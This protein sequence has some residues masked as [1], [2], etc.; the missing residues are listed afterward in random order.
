MTFEYKA[1]FH[2]HSKYSDGSFQVE[3]LVDRVAS[4]NKSLTVEKNISIKGLA[5]V[6]HDFYPDESTEAAAKAYA[7]KYGIELLFGSEISADNDKVHIVGYGIDASNFSFQRHVVKEQ[8]KRLEAFEATCRLLNNFFRREG[9]NIDLDRDVGPK[10]LKRDAQGRIEPNGPL[11]WHYLRQAMVERGMAT[12][13]KEAN[14]LIGPVGPCYHQRETI[15][16]V[17][18]VERVLKWGGK[19][20]LAHP[21]KIPE[22]YR[23][24][25][26][27]S[28]CKAGLLGIEAYTG[29][30]H[31]PEAKNSYVQI[32]KDHNLMVLSGTDLHADIND[33]GKFLLPYEVLRDFE[34]FQSKFHCH[35]G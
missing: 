7:S 26:V 16:S 9:K 27:K 31:E 8:Y 32:A 3:A 15:D 2:N 12:T 24:L 21:H 10:T 4:L 17:T 28:L 23:E 25:V 20:V 19:P 14:I 35:D 1:S 5:I 30:Y 6:D 34:S 11:R 22:E 29:S 33:I 13:T 18:A